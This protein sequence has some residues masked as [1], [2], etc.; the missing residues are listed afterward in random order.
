[1]YS[2]MD[3]F[4][5]A[6]YV[7]K[8]NITEQEL[9]FINEQVSVSEKL[10][11]SN[12]M[13]NE[14]YLLDSKELTSL[15]DQITKHLNVYI[16][17]VIGYDIELYVTQSWSN[18][19]PKGSSHHT[20]KHRNSIISGV[21]YLTD[22]PA[23]FVLMKPDDELL[24]PDMLKSTQ[25]NSPVKTVA[26]QNNDIMLFPSHIRHGVTQNTNDATRVSLAFNS[27]YRGV[28]GS[29]LQAMMKVEIK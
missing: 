14:T 1:M 27:F 25:Y 19:N 18:Y 17:D 23:P 26:V 6:V 29:D 7:S 16:R 24:V 3:A 5:T 11:Y 2:V 22:D 9:Q 20:H 10:V 8:V 4:P 12:Y 21:I 13:S 15:K 28:L